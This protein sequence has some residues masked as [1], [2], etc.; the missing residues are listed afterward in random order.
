M[1]AGFPVGRYA[2][3]GGP[4]YE[5]DAARSLIRVLVY[6]GGRMARMGHDHVVASRQ[7]GGFVLGTPAGFAADL[8]VAL[9]AMSVD[10]PELRAD[11]GFTTEP[12]AEDRDGTRRNM[13]KSVDAAAHPFVTVSLVAPPPI[14]GNA[15]A[16]VTMTLHGVS[17]SFAV[18][19]QVRVEAATLEASGTFE[20]RQSD[21]GI[22]PF[23]VLGGALRVED[24]LDV[25]FELRAERVTDT[26]LEALSR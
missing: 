13:L 18:P 1:P 19:V 8:Y 7:V 22:E 2:G 5:I 26:E 9:A 11:A 23:S 16:D 25:S 10:E 17:R 21:F 4:V 24:R 20:L 15:V 14:A 12:S 3:P 6:R